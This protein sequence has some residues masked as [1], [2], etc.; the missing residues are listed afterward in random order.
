MAIE[1]MTLGEA[2]EGGYEIV[3][4]EE[5]R[6]TAPPTWLETSQLIAAEV[7]PSIAGGI[8]GSFISPIAGSAVGGAAGSAF[9]NQ[10]AQNLRMEMG[11]GDRFSGGELAAA[12]LTGAIPMGRLAKAGWKTNAAFRASQGAGLST[13]ELG[14]QDALDSERDFTPEQYAATAL[15]GGVA[16]GV[17]GTVEAKFFRDALD[18]PNIQEGMTRPQLV[19]EVKKQADDFVYREAEWEVVDDMPSWMKSAPEGIDVKNT[20]ALA[21]NTVKQLEDLIV[22][23]LDNVPTDRLRQETINQVNL[24]TS[25]WGKKQNQP[26][27]LTGDVIGTPPMPREDIDNFSL[28]DLKSSMTDLGTTQIDELSDIRQSIDKLDAYQK[29]HGKLVKGQRKQR[30]YLLQR[31]KELIAGLPSN[32]A[33]GKG[34]TDQ[35][36]NTLALEQEVKNVE[37][38]Q[39]STTD[40]VKRKQFAEE[41]RKIREQIYGERHKL[42]KEEQHAKDFFNNDKFNS[43]VASGGLMA[44][45]PVFLMEDEGEE[46]QSIASLTG[47]GILSAILG[48]LFL[49]KAA[50]RIKSAMRNMNKQVKMPRVDKKGKVH[51]EDQSIDY[52]EAKVKEAGDASTNPYKHSNWGTVK[53][54]LRNFYEHTVRPLSRQLKD[55]NPII[56]TAFQRVEMRIGTMRK[57]LKDQSLFIYAMEAAA[58]RG[59]FMDEFRDAWG[60]EG[61]EAGVAMQRLFN[62][63]ENLIQQEGRRLA[64]KAGLRDADEVKIGFGAGSGTHTHAMY[65]KAL[66]ELYIDLGESG[67]TLGYTRGYNPRMVKDYNQLRQYL[68]SQGAEYIPVIEAEFKEYAKKHKMSV[69]DLSDF[70]KA[71]IAS[72]LFNRGKVDASPGFTRSRKFSE[73][74]KNIRDAYVDPGKAL[75]AYIDQAS[76]KTITRTFLGKQLT[77]KGKDIGFQSLDETAAAQFAKKIGASHGI[78][79]ADGLRKLQEVI[80]KRFNGE[81]GDPLVQLWRN[82]NYLTTIANV[83]TTITQLMDLVNTFWFAGSNNTMQA[84]LNKQRRDWFSELGLD[85]GNGVDFGASSGGMNKLLDQV[86]SATG[87]NQLDKWAKNVSLDALHKKFVKEAKADAGKLEA[88]LAGEFGSDQAREMVRQL[89]E[90]NGSIDGKTPTPEGIQLLLF[91]KAADFLPISRLEMPGAASGR[92][93]PLFYQLKTYTIK[94]L[95]IYREIN[96][97]KLQQAK[98]LIDQGKFAEAAKVGGPA[99]MDLAKYGFLLGAAGASTDTIKDVLYNRPVEIE[100]QVKNNILRLALINRYHVYRAERDGIGKAALDLV[101]PATTMIDRTS[102]DIG[103]FVSGEDV[104]G[105]ALQGTILDAVYWGMPGMG[106]FEKAR[107]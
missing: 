86:L 11:F 56:N 7:V 67:M 30:D 73:I 69:K 61:G 70:E 19:G 43:F 89:K 83:G 59:G 94:Q 38:A 49:G 8:A 36:R 13:L 68:E 92:F 34:Y 53:S 72:R 32:T 101:M 46:G 88:E 96:Q 98:K 82:A 87:F 14:I 103:A 21:E 90:W 47:A 40:P 17:L 41:A 65:R 102:K 20:E 44:G 93:A 107:Q 79:D 106:G 9:G 105:H 26:A 25:S 84:M 55:L 28:S 95:D 71:Q 4:A 23:E 99:M 100:D 50:P 31:E 60:K 6:R 5:A 24:P 81:S 52:T 75:S 3:G 1:Y 16:G 66:D 91:K 22:K 12:T 57:R 76:E 15:F 104:K 63:H 54:S 27:Q 64:K 2:I 18:N 35:Y 33:L 39:Q 78:N 10:W 85:R 97:G 51:P 80:Q 48:G 74:D 37:M 77:G 45:I 62:E 42:S 58:K 29:K